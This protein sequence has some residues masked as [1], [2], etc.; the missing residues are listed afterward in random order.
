MELWGKTGKAQ[1]VPR[2]AGFDSSSSSG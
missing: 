1:L 2:R